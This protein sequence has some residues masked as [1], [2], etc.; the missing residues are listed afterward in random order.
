MKLKRL[1][2]NVLFIVD[3]AK[4]LMLRVKA[5][6]A[7]YSGPPRCQCL[8]VCRVRLVPAGLQG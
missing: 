1:H 6:Q 3:R 4:C 7:E 8:K 2:F 5:V